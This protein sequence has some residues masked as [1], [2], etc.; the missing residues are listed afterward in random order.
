M[1]KLPKITESVA[2]QVWMLKSVEDKK[3]FLLNYMEEGFNTTDQGLI[4]VRLAKARSAAAVDTLVTNMYLKTE[5][6]ST[7]W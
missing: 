2:K 7:S 3:A 6:M 1:T 5:G 4:R